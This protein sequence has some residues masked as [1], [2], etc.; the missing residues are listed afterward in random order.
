MFNI[1]EMAAV[2]NNVHILGIVITCISL[3]NVTNS[4]HF[5]PTGC[6]MTYALAHSFQLRLR[7]GWHQT[8]TSSKAALTPTGREESKST[9]HSPPTV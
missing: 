7:I 8:T 4:W 9:P 3:H 5:T 6:E 2:N 1:V